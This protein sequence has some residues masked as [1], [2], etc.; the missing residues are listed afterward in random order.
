MEME[1]QAILGPKPSAQPEPTT[2]AVLVPKTEPNLVP[3]TEPDLET[4]I[5]NSSSA[6]NDNAQQSAGSLIMTIKRKNGA[7][8]PETQPEEQPPL[9]RR[10]TLKHFD[11]NS[12]NFGKYRILIV[13][14]KDRQKSF[15]NEQ[16]LCLVDALEKK[17]FSLSATEF[18]PVL[19]DVCGY[20]N[21]F[22]ISCHTKEDRAW[23]QKVVPDLTVWK[24]AKL[25]VELPHVD[26]S[27]TRA[28]TFI[29][30]TD[31]ISNFEII[32]RIK[33]QNPDLIT[34]KWATC[35]MEYDKER[36][37]ISIVFAVDDESLKLIKAMGSSVY[38]GIGRIAMKIQDDVKVNNG[39]FEFEKIE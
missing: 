16:T 4:N 7:Y 27:L 18:C 36:K 14:K 23:L 29:H 24:G 15:T 38:Y 33:N 34:E 37:G 12:F 26:P 5:E 11:T 6:P 21:M 9:K 30:R 25:S 35:E 3:K 32:R 31:L 20:N 10:T 2:G 28:E 8:F 17:I 22:S 19:G 13:D 39:G 1:T